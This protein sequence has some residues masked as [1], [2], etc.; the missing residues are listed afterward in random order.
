MISNPAQSYVIDGFPRAID[1]AQ[2]FE[3]SVCETQLL[4]YYDIP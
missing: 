2:F 4:I 1:Q 3:Q